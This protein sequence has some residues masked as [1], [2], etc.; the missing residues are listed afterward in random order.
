MGPLE[1]HYFVTL[2]RAQPE[3]DPTH[4]K[5]L[6]RDL[7]NLRKSFQISIEKKSST[8][9]RFPFAF[10]VFCAFGLFDSTPTKKISFNILADI[11]TNK[12]KRLCSNCREWDISP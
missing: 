1:T 3:K 4:L 9:P 6:E 12:L 8:V 10:E 11:A 2:V 5:E 7:K